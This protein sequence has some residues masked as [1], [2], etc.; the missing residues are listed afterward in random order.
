MTD[1]GQEQI[2][3]IDWCLEMDLS[4]EERGSK[5]QLHRFFFS[6]GG[7]EGTE[8]QRI[9]AS[10]LKGH[11]PAD[12]NPT[13]SMQRPTEENDLMVADLMVNEGLSGARV[14]AA[15]HFPTRNN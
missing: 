9:S 14:K 8:G 15:V 7:S 12:A 2:M 5:Q 4:Q 3:A 6:R 11:W 13:C 10:P 1:G